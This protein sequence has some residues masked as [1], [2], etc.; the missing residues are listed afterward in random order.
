MPTK[1]PNAKKKSTGRVTP[2]KQLAPVDERVLVPTP[3]SDWG[4]DSPVVPEDGFVTE[5]PSGKVAK[6]RRTLDLPILLQSGQIPNP[7][8]AILREQ[9]E[10]L[11]PTITQKR[12]A[13]GMSRS[14]TV[15]ANKQMLQLLEDQCMEIMIDPKLS[16]PI[17]QGRDPKA[18]PNETW[19]QYLER[20]KDW[21][22]DPGTV[23]IF[24]VAM[25]DKFYLMA[26]G[27]GMATDLASFRAAEA[28]VVVDVQASQNM[29][30]TPKLATGA[31]GGNRAARRTKTRA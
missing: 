31:G 25:Q 3:A 6:V 24:K 5:L 11:D 19:E 16:R 9:M 26:V 12:L 15:S 1:K 2:K 29:A 21:E 22:P 7:L 28:S 18:G 27:Q 10:T 20:I 4:E 8:A 13:E 17:P 14:D 23:S 30:R